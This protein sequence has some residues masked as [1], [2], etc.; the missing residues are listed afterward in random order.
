MNV[1]TNGTAIFLTFGYCQIRKQQK[2]QIFK[3]Y[4]W[5]NIEPKNAIFA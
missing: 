4:S 5:S 1:K 3:L 2:R